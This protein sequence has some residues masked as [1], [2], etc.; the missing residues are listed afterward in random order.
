MGSTVSTFAL[1]RQ[2]QIR[3]LM[4]NA[5]YYPQGAVGCLV[6]P[7]NKPKYVRDLE[8]CIGATKRL[9]NGLKKSSRTSDAKVELPYKQRL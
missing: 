3:G 4:G 9:D 5:T 8:E 6:V 2:I 1:S 7:V